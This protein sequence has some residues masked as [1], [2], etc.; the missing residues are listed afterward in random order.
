[1]MRV[2]VEDESESTE[3]PNESIEGERQ[4]MDNVENVAGEMVVEESGLRRSN[5]LRRQK[6]CDCCHIAK[7]VKINEPKS[8]TEALIGT[9]SENW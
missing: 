9:Y 8:V 6:V 7:E 3:N 1:M 2:L 5:R 4:G